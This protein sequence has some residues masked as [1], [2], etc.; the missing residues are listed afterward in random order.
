MRNA[1]KLAMGC[2]SV[3][4][5]ALRFVPCDGSRIRAV[6]RFVR[7]RGER[8]PRFFSAA[9]SIE[10]DLRDRAFQA[11]LRDLVVDQRAE[12]RLVSRRLAM[13]HPP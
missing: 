9:A 5:H 12:R 10:R 7:T 13:N 2:L 6:V 1:Y 3:V 8:P 11:R 4:G